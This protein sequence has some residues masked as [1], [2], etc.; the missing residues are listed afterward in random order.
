MTVVGLRSY[1]LLQ[2]HQSRTTRKKKSTNVPSVHKTRAL[3]VRPVIGQMTR[4]ARSIPKA[5]YIAKQVLAALTKT[6]LNVHHNRL[7][8]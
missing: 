2:Q 6:F 7:D 1:R 5:W 8:Q 4:M 3:L